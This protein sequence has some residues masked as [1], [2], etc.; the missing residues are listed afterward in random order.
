[1][2]RK[3]TF[4]IGVAGGVSS[5][6]KDVCER[7]LEH[8]AESN[9]Q[10]EKKILTINFDS[11]YKSL[12]NEEK[13]SA[14]YGEHN[15]DHPSAFDDQ[16]AYQTIVD[17]VEGKE[18]NVPLYDCKHYAFKENSSAISLAKAGKPDVIIIRGVLVFYYEK[19]RDMFDLKLFVD[20]DA[21]SRLSKRVV[22]EMAA[23]DRDLEQILNYYVR[24]VKPCFEEFCLPTKKYADVIIPR[25]PGN[26][27]AIN[28]IVAHIDDILNSSQLIVKR[29]NSSELN[30]HY[31][32]L[33]N[34][35]NRHM[36][37]R[38]RRKKNIHS[39]KIEVF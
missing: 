18:V 9:R 23:Y 39:L 37:Y 33:T 7:I 20:C 34:K 28:L 6:K 38:P 25:G 10:S 3:K 31:Y 11:F 22:H 24:F 36:S 5:G 27:V 2:S 26:H 8:F 29:L 4:L 21:D 12:T 16:L 32:D 13:T 14:K 19:I 15:F 17:I 1:M 30:V 35:Y